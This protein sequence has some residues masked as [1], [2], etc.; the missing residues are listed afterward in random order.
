[1]GARQSTVGSP[2]AQAEGRRQR[3]ISCLSGA[4]VTRT[5]STRAWARPPWPP[6]D[7][8]C[9][10][11]APLDDSC[12]HFPRGSGDWPLTCPSSPLSLWDFETPWKELSM[13]LPLSSHFWAS[14]RVAASV[15][16]ST[17]TSKPLHRSLSQQ[18][19]SSPAL[20]TKPC[21][22][23]SFKVLNSGRRCWIHHHPTPW[24]VPV[25]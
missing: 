1:M 9:D 20:Q 13:T 12:L 17:D 3:G 10:F 18:D 21:I 19:P 6:R 15:P 22:P 14:S 23:F 8:S 7:S 2:H 4:W 5:V 24:P 25:S 16:L 11:T